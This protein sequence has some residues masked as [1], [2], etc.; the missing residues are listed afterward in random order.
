MSLVKNVDK[1]VLICIQGEKSQ[2]D[3]DGQ[4][5]WHVWGRE[6]VHTGL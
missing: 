3:R 4:D 1:H 2:E 6:E 5:M